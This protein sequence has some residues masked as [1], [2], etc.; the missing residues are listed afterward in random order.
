MQSVPSGS[1]GLAPRAIGQMIGGIIPANE[2]GQTLN[3]ADADNISLD[4]CQCCANGEAPAK[5]FLA[6]CRVGW[7]SI[8]SHKAT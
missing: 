8:A 1:H 6:S 5:N 2:R 3:I 7:Q 4:R